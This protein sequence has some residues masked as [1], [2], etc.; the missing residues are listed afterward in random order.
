[1]GSIPPP[2]LL[3]GFSRWVS[4]V[5]VFLVG[6]EE[7]I[8]NVQRVQFGL[9]SSRFG[10]RH[11]VFQK[12]NKRL[13]FCQGRAH[14]TCCS[15]TGFISHVATLGR[16]SNSRIHF[17]HEVVLNITILVSPKARIVFQFLL[18]CHMS[19]YLSKQ[20]CMYLSR[21]RS[22]VSSRGEVSV[23]KLRFSLHVCASCACQRKQ[24]F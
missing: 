17:V 20:I 21:L 18:T 11:P 7:F 12:E 6:C 22:F 4:A 19:R 23:K 2:F 15:H 16:S 9:K 3:L 5:R 10:F 14:I 24:K 13:L 8:S 1:M